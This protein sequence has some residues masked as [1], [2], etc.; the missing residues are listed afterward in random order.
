MHLKPKLFKSVTTFVSEES[1]RS[2]DEYLYTF[3]YIAYCGFICYLC[4]RRSR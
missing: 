2:K 3:V 4:Y 1:E